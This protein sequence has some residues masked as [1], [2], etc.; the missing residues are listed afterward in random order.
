[1]AENAG[2]TQQLN[3]VT[4]SIAELETKIE[5]I[6]FIQKEQGASQS[7]EIQT[8][9]TDEMMGYVKSITV[10]STTHAI[11]DLELVTIQAPVRIKRGSCSKRR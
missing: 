5:Q 6:R 2:L 1:M 3:I 8:E 10:Y 7:T 4:Q 9:F 11:V